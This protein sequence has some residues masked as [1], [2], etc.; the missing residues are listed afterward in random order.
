MY[1]PSSDIVVS[2]KLVP[3]RRKKLVI[4]IIKFNRYLSAKSGINQLNQLFYESV[5]NYNPDLILI[6]HSDNRAEGDTD[7]ML[8]T[9]VKL[10]YQSPVRG[11]ATSGWRGRSLSLG[12]ADAVTVLSKSGLFIFRFGFFS[13]SSI[14]ENS[15]LIASSNDL[16]SNF[17]FTC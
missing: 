9:K 13:K 16:C 15:E 17:C 11:I 5:Q 14:R 8:K 6:G 3:V 1:C 12:I 4:P 2:A 10:N 7:L